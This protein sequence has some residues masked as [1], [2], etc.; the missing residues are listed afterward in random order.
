LA[1]AAFEVVEFLDAAG[2]AAVAE[3]RG[4]ERLGDFADF[5]VVQEIG[6]ETEN[7]AVIGFPGEA[8][9]DLIVSEGGADATDL[10]GGDGHADTAA[11]KENAG[12]AAALGDGEGEGNGV[13]GV[14][15]TGQGGLAAKILYDVAPL[16]ESG[17]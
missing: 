8:S 12:F 11:V 14:I 4:E 10:I 5:G 2:M 7:I 6:A 1:L 13:I 16:S 15:G 17:D 9:G 3:G